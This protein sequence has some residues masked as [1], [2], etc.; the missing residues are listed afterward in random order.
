MLEGAHALDAILPSVPLALGVGVL[1][2]GHTWMG[3]SFLPKW[4]L[5][6]FS[7]LVSLLFGRLF[8][9]LHSQWP[10]ASPQ[11]LVSAGIVS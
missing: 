3:R 2:V 4:I 8:V 7:V 10:Q 6:T 5:L 11:T 1:W 9:V